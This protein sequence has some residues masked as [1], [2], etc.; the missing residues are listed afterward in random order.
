MIGNLWSFTSYGNGSVKA[1]LPV[2]SLVTVLVTLL[3]RAHAV[4]EVRLGD[5]GRIYGDL[6]ESSDMDA[7]FVRIRTEDGIE[8]ELERKLVSD[9]SP[10]SAEHAEYRRKA[11]ETA[12]SAD[13]HFELAQWC[14]ENGL[15]EE[16]DKHLMRAIEIDANHEEARS[17]LG[18]DRVGDEWL[19]NREQKAR[20]GLFRYGSRWKTRQE[21]ELLEA[22][23]NRELA[24]KHWLKTIKTWSKSARRGN[25]DIIAEQL[26]AID[27]PVAVPA[28]SQLIAENG[29]LAL[30]KLF[31][32]T[33]GRIAS[34]DA[35]GALAHHALNGR[36][37][38]L[39][40]SCVDELRLGNHHDAAGHFIQALSNE[41]NAIVN[42]AAR[43]LRELKSEHAVAALINSV[44]TSHRRTVAPRT[45]GNTN[46]SFGSGPGG[47]PGGLSVGGGGPR[48]AVIDVPNQAVVD[49]L[50]SITGVN[51]GF[52]EAAWRRWY[53][54]Q[55]KRV[56]IDLRRD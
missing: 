15:I 34:R 50:E 21:I 42:R 14:G 22:R 3:G 1:S 33:L 43:A 16:E 46:V 37:E 53:A 13:A 47:S 20:E 5:G 45:V 30:N 54:G 35:I 7:A 18:Y 38:E 52:D 2:M 19:T 6:I 29:S 39:R 9:I 44:V 49:A 17:A 40:L 27:D 8:I 12:E 56:P 24:E 55:T 51:L 23:K 4:E 26:A 11:R 10:E 25:A 48:V 36:T 41:N 32:R 31:V 28:L